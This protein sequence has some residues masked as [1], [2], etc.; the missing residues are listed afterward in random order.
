MKFTININGKPITT[1]DGVVQ[2][3]SD[4]SIAAMN[5][6]MCEN[7]GDDVRIICHDL[8][9]S[10]DMLSMFLR[11]HPKGTKGHRHFWSWLDGLSKDFINETGE[12]PPKDYEKYQ[13]YH[14]LFIRWLNGK[15]ETQQKLEI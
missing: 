6:K 8:G 14:K 11:A 2:E 13:R 9:D 12:K 7:K 4:Y 3:F 5:F 15:I 10:S 1:S